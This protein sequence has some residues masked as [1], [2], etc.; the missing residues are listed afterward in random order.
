LPEPQEQRRQILH[1]L[2]QALW[3][4][5]PEVH[6]KLGQKQRLGQVSSGILHKQDSLALPMPPALK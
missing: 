5:P 2:P 1:V 6:S 3:A 4:M